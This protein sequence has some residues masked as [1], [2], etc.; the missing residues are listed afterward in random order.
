MLTPETDKAPGACLA[1]R[2]STHNEEYQAILSPEALDFLGKLVSE[3]GERRNGL[4]A[5]RDRKQQRFDAGALPDFREDTQAIRND[6]SWQVAPIPPALQDRRVEITGP[7]DRKMV[8]N[9]LNSGAKV[10]MCCFEDASSPTWENMVEGQINLRDANRGTISFH[11]KQKNKHYTLNDDPALLIAR[12]RGLHLPEQS[13]TFNGQP[14]PG[15]LMDFALYFFH[16]YQARAEQGLGVYYYIPK[17]ESME[18]AQWWDDVFRFTEDHFDVARGTIRATV[19]IETLPAVFQMEEMLYAMK[20]HIVAMN[21]GRWDYIFSYIKTL[22]KHPDRIL[23][24]RHGIG[25]DQPFLNAYSQLLVR[26]CHARGAL[27]MGG[28]SAFI[29]AKDPAE[30]EKVTAK[31]IEDKAREARNGH[32]GTW[33]AHPALVDLAMSVF[34]QYLDGQP[35]QLNFQSPTHPIPAELLLQPCPGTRDEAGVRKNIRIALYYIE[36]WIQGMGCV[37]IYGLMEDAA[38]AEISRAN[39]WQWIHHGITLDDG[40]RFTAELFQTWLY[41]ELETIKQEVGDTRYA[42]GR[43]KE[44]AD[45]FYKLSTA[46]AFANFLTLPSYALLQGAA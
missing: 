21:C 4:L 20:D 19:L 23:P 37:P 3:F 7:V 38:T 34:N 9:A 12:P 16:N 43:F 35:N 8:I 14:I 33:V 17:L 36:A 15:C 27:A 24:D 11:D 45:L 22:K 28:M 30:M 40:Q 31:V 39:I 46:D 41:Q 18:E 5:E 13:I 29:P 25:M 26:T 6:K 2:G 1:V 10:F 44:T 42:A 32:D